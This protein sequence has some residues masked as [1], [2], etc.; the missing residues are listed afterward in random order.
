MS[1]LHHHHH[2]ELLNTVLNE[3]LMCHASVYISLLS[4]SPSIIGPAVALNLI[5]CLQY[6]CSDF[7]L[8]SAWVPAFPVKGHRSCVCDWIR[9][10]LVAMWHEPLQL[11]NSVTSSQ[12]L[13][14]HLSDMC[15][16]H[17]FFLFPCYM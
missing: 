1:V 4:A 11:Q 7:V 6:L 2:R 16:L 12:S 17:A 15:R 10:R 13:F 9:D 3:N 5:S 8:I 14:L